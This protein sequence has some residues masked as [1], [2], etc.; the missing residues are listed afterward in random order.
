MQNLILFDDETRDHLLPLTFTRPVSDLR[1]GILKVSEKW[2]HDLNGKVSYITSEYLT[3]KYPI[4]IGEDNLVINGLVL[5]NPQL[6]KIIDALDRNEAVMW[7]GD[8]VA[9]RIPGHEFD[10]LIDGT[11]GEEISGYSLTETPVTKISRCWDLFALCGDEITADFERLTAGRKSAALHESNT[12]IGD[13]AVFLEEGATVM[14][15]V[16][17]T[18]GGPVY[19]G[20]D[21]EI[22]EGSQLRG[23]IALGTGS[24]VKMGAKIYGPSSFGPFCKVGGEVNNVVFQGYSNKGHDGFLG[25]SVLGEWCNLG[26]DTNCSNLK[27]TYSTVRAW[28]Y[29]LDDYE[30][31]D[32]QFCGLIMGDHSKSSINTMFNTGSVVGVA[33][34]LFGAGFPAKYVPSFTW[35]RSDSG[36]HFQLDK[37]LSTA[38]AMMTRRNLE[39][40]DHDRLILKHLFDLETGAGSD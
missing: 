5:P 16:I 20:R 17:N 33:A 36:Q 2:A 13:G 8:L 4:E 40:S 29:A 11:F 14:C 12:V 23:P 15:S 6:V 3:G 25:N 39:L 32:R 31:T 24:V 19:V 35:G 10:A 38:E 37:V 27:N 26:A 34:N 7:D 9:A 30:L 1:V 21:A 28:N 18:S 22:M